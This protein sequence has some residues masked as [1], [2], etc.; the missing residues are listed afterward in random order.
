MYVILR[1]EF[2]SANVANAFVKM[3]R[4]Q[5]EVERF[6]PYVEFHALLTRRLELSIR[7]PCTP[8]DLS[9]YLAFAFVV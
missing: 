7:S 8:G 9:S 3:Q 2:M 1:F 5:L 4:L 6:Y